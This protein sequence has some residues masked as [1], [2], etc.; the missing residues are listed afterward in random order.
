[1]S[2]FIIEAGTKQYMVEP[3]KKLNVDR[4]NEAAI[5][6]TVELPCL[7][8]FGDTTPKTIKAKVL[9]HIKGTKIR[10]VKFKSK[11]NYHKVSG[12]RPFQTTLEIIG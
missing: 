9:D 11:S 4:I 10:V 7:F 5:G 1:M 6:S 3:G 2:Q 8:S 12:F